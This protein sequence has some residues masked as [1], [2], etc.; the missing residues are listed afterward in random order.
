MFGLLDVWTLLREQQLHYQ[1]RFNILTP[2]EYTTV[3][4]IHTIHMFGLLDVW[5]LL[6][7]QQFAS[8]LP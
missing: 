4:Q 8:K 3:S 6:R 7:E 2:S 1:V 5:T